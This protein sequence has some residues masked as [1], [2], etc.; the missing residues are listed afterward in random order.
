MPRLGLMRSHAVRRVAG[1]RNDD[2]ATDA[3][4]RFLAPTIGALEFGLCDARHA[5]TS[6]F[7]AV[8]RAFAARALI[9]PCST[10]P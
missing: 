6:A 5:G 1:I 2:A 8:S 7:L 9:R 4:T 3:G 10:Q